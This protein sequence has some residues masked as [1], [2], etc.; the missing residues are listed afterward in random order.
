MDYGDLAV[1]VADPDGLKK[2]QVLSSAVSDV[3][4]ERWRVSMDDIEPN[5]LVAAKAC[6]DASG[7]GEYA[8]RIMEQATNLMSAFEEEY[9]RGPFTELI[10]DNEALKQ[11]MLGTPTHGSWREGV[12]FDA[13]VKFEDICKVA[14]RTIHTHRGLV[15]KMRMCRSKCTLAKK[16]FEDCASAVSKM[17]ASFSDE[18]RAALQNTDL[19]MLRSHCTMAEAQLLQFMHRDL[20]MSRE[21][22]AQEVEKVITKID[23]TTDALLYVHPCLIVAGRRFIL[24]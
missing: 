19:Y 12:D 16:K 21:T 24:V 10:D 11:V 6:N 14:D 7:K 13:G 8:V 15:A 1:Q 22:R 2:F 18:E 4:V 20:R 23:D 5:V 9:L 17:P 3:R